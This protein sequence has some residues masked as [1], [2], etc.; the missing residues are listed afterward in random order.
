MS[1]M[2]CVIAIPPVH[3]DVYMDLPEDRQHLSDSEDSKALYTS[4]NHS[5]IH[6]DILMMKISLNMEQRNTQTHTQSHKYT[7]VLLENLRTFSSPV[8]GVPVHV[9]TDG[10]NDVTVMSQSV[11]TSMYDQLDARV[12]LHFTSELFIDWPTLTCSTQTA[13][14]GSTRGQQPFCCKDLP[15]KLCAV[16]RFS[17]KMSLDTAASIFTSILISLPVPAHGKHPHSMM[18]PPPCFTVGIELAL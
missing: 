8:H 14:G 7:E 16:E 4:V 2:C 12:W 5:S 3:S 1:S 17:S 18:L 9:P 15:P 6:S 13:C 10:A 11:R